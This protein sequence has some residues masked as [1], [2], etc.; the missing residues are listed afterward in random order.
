MSNQKLSKEEAIKYRKQGLSHQQIADI[1]QCSKVWVSK[2]VN[3]IPKGV[4][5][6]AVDETRIQ[7]ILLVRDL[8][9]QLEAL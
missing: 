4:H 3:G 9:R 6:V 7:A 8:L 1:M 5:K 2:A